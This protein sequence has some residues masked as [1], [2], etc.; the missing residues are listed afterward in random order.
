MPTT[1]SAMMDQVK[2]EPEGDPLAI[3]TSD[4]SLEDKKTF[5]EEAD[6]LNLLSTKIKPECEDLAP[7]IKLEGTPVPSNSATVKCEAEELSCYVNTVKEEIL[8]EE[9]T[10]EVEVTVQRYPRQSCVIR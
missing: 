7:G 3:Q 5:S 6:S 2:A 9:T 8:L 1:D 10:H 4:N